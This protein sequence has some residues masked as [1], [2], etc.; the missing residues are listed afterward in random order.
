MIGET[1]KMNRLD[2]GLYNSANACALPSQAWTLDE[3]LR[4]EGYLVIQNFAKEE[5]GEF[6]NENG[7]GCYNLVVNWCCLCLYLVVVC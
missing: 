2:A 5:E 4:E 7:I 3:G 6:S 1:I